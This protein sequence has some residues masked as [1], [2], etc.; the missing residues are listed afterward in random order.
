M[1]HC[2]ASVTQT[3]CDPQVVFQSQHHHRAHPPGQHE[4][5]AVQSQGLLL[6]C[7]FQTGKGKSR[8]TILVER[9]TLE[10]SQCRK[11]CHEKV[12]VKNSKNLSNC[13]RGAKILIFIYIFK[14]ELMDLNCFYHKWLYLYCFSQCKYH[15]IF[16]EF[17]KSSGK[18]PGQHA[19]AH[20]F[21]CVWPSLLPMF[22]AELF[23]FA[24]H[25]PSSRERPRH[26][27]CFPSAASQV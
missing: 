21:I 20:T 15:T 11:K 23:C 18:F 1:P 12:K 7:S 3:F 26:C 13:F 16:F 10:I 14:C 24:L 9:I 4:I 25:Y 19:L 8:W 27:H 17:V 2:I 22:A 6:L 5:H